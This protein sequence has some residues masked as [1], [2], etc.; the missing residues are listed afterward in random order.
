MKNKQQILKNKQL[1]PTTTENKGETFEDVVKELE[2]ALSTTAAEYIPRACTA[3]KRHNPL[4]TSAQIRL[5][6]LNN[7][8]IKRVWKESTIRQYWTDWMKNPNMIK[9]GLAAQAAHAAR[10]EKQI[11]KNNSLIS[12]EDIKTSINND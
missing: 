9:S 10:K 3:L 12:Q 7:N 5:R 8:T 4:I 6:I 11:S 1:K 2:D